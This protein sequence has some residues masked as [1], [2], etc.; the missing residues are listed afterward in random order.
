MRDRHR[1]QPRFPELVPT[2]RFGA[3]SA[4]EG[5]TTD[6]L[7]EWLLRR[8]VFSVITRLNA[9]SRWTLG[10]VR[11]VAQSIPSVLNSVLPAC[12]TMLDTCQV[13]AAKLRSVQR[14]VVNPLSGR[15]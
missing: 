11:Y 5:Q 4:S 13:D 15:L 14:V 3:E 7:Y 12:R 1:G 9:N 6:F 2:G 10:S 8:L